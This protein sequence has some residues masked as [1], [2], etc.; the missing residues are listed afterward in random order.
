MESDKELIEKGNSSFQCHQTILKDLSILFWV[1]IFL[2]IIQ[3]FTTGHYF[4][5]YF[6]VIVLFVQWFYLGKNKAILDI[7][8]YLLV[9]LKRELNE[10][11][12]F[13]AG[14]KKKVKKRKN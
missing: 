9:K 14:I 1:L 11:R 12:R 4:I 2:T 13:I 3:S 10:K 6:A 8:K 7:Q 5:Y